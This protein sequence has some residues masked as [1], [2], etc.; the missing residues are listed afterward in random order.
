VRY[1]VA[2]GASMRTDWRMF[3]VFTLASYGLQ[4]TTVDGRRSAEE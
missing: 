3:L 1:T 2:T 4:L